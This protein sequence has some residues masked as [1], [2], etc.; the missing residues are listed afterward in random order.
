MQ[1]I[2]EEL[3]KKYQSC[4]EGKAASYIPELTKANPNDFGIVVTTVKGEVF[5][6]GNCDVNFTLQSTSKPFTYGLVLEDFGRNHVLTKVG[7]EPTGEAFNSIV[8]LEKHTHLPYNPMINSGA[9]AV[10]ALI[11]APTYEDRVKRVLTLF[12]SYV[13]HSLKIDE[14]VF[15]SERNTAHR[16][17]S[18]AHLLR[19][20]NVIEDDIENSLDVYFKQCS[21]LANTIDLSM[22]AATLANQGLNPLT[23]VTALKPDYVGDLL[24]LMFTCG[25]YDSSGE[26]AYSVGIPAKSGVSG[27][28]LGVIPG[29]MGI[30]V[31]SPLID[32]KGH[33]V[34]GVKVFQEL[35][36]RLNLSI[37]RGQLS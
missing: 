5:K 4:T 2:I 9:I 11:K 10:S 18:I 12:E 33:S 16:N 35:S 26:W 15:L 24:S 36:Q 28:I 32:E 14:S 20:F 27:G 29:K 13:G 3:H 22:M 17:R 31:Y 21:I 6:T 23:K 1:L 30:A 25:M 19:H 34:R 7:V 8:E 37:F